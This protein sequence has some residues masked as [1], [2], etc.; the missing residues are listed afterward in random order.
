MMMDELFFEYEKNTLCARL[1]GEIDHHRAAILREEIDRELFSQ[2][3]PALILDLSGVSFM[4]SAGL[5]LVMGRYT[6]AAEIGCRFAVR[7]CSD[8]IKKIFA[9][10]GMDKVITIK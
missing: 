3:P 9:L 10:S 1:S 2:Q 5:G 6:K 7:G 4:D 8:R